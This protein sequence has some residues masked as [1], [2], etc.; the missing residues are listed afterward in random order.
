MASKT[1]P[2]G[3]GAA[4]YGTIQNPTREY[5]AFTRAFDYFDGRLFGD[6]LPAC[7]ITLQRKANARGYFSHKMFEAR[8]ASG[9]T[10]E[11]ALNPDTFKGR[12]DAE[13]LS[14]L[15]H[16]M[17]HLWQYQFGRPGRSRYHNKEWA[18]RMEAL[19]L[20][21]TSTGQPGGKRTGQR[22]THLI[23]PGG[24]F[25]LAAAELLGGGFQ[26]TWQSRPREGDG[27]AAQSKVKYTC[28]GCGQNAWAKPGARLDC[29]DCTTRMEAQP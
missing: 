20:T 15:V 16:E 4:L 12:T 19:G 6:S 17:V 5:D 2:A 9:Q 3:E 23:V 24:P 28:P 27:R 21:P 1:R 8:A 10:D 13:I 18:D 25:D 14:T 26:L 11:I 7:L 29:G 22:V